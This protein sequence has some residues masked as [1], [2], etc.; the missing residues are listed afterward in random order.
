MENFD[1]VQ[2]DEEDE[3]KFYSGDAYVVLYA[4]NNGTKDSYMIYYWLVSGEPGNQ[5]FKMK[6]LVGYLS[7]SVCVPC[8]KLSATKHV[9]NKQKHSP[10]NTMS[11]FCR[12]ATARRTSR[13]RPRSRQWSWTSVSAAALC[14]YVILDYVI[15]S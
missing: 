15:L 10:L 13:V 8:T 3:N 7:R 9:S 5:P 1:L 2:V 11:A 4:F 6:G 14:R 12:G